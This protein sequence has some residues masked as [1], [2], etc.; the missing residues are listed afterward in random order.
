MLKEDNSKIEEILSKDI[1]NHKKNNFKDEYE[2][3]RINITYLF[4]SRL[5]KKK[6]KNGAGEGN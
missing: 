6:L 5:V 4:G 2:A 1:E 3:R